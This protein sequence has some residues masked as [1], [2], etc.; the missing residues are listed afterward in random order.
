MGFLGKLR[1]GVRQ[2]K[3]SR[4]LGKLRG[5]VGKIREGFSQIKGGCSR[6]LNFKFV[7]QD[8]FFQAS[9]NF[10]HKL[11]EGFRQFKWGFWQFKGGFR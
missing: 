1:G 3:G 11:R 10:L 6:G 7:R 8:I 9:H 5:V 4:I 2:G